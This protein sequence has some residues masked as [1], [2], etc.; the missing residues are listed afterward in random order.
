MKQLVFGK[1]ESSSLN[2]LFHPL[3]IYKKE[4]FESV[5]ISSGFLTQENKKFLPILFKEV[6]PL[7][8]KKG[9]LHLSYSTDS[10]RITPLEIEQNL[11]WLYK[12]QYTILTHQSNRKNYSISL[13]KDSKEEKKEEGID[14]WTFGMV[15]NGVRKDFIEQSL[16]SIRSL[17]I[18]HYEIVI[19][20]RYQ[21]EKSRDIVYIP[22]GQRDEKGWITKKKNIIA[23]S[24]SYTNL[25]IFH[26]RIV[27]NSD[28]HRGMKQ[29]GNNFEVLSCRQLFNNR[30]R[31]GD[32]VTTNVSMSDKG[33]VY[34]IEELDYRDWD[35]KAYIG[36]QLVMM[37]KYVWGQEPW[38]ESVYW[39]E[40]ED[41]EYS[42]RLTERGYIPRFNPYSSTTTLSWR[43]GKLPIKPFSKNQ[44]PF[45]YF[46][47]N[48]PIRRTSRFMAYYGM[49]IPFVIIFI[50]IL[51]SLF[52]KTKIYT[53][54]REH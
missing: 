2:N 26:D 15:T 28:W 31:A 52:S 53:I 6:F 34:K 46:F 8:K 10:A 13:R 12:L 54:I 21:G 37:K 51:Y 42:H 43:F 41:I 47:H 14:H 19:C 30:L 39:G 16:A 4:Q 17:K 50:R 25:C 20:G 29:Y 7:L 5:E 1:R 18:Q 44:V 49:K 22:F 45:F 35:R 11:W 38:N 27:F 9:I 36:G 23:K 33:F 3:G 40:G 48:V 32:W 24:A